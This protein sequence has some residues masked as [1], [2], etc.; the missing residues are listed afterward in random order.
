MANALALI[1]TGIYVLGTGYFLDRLLVNYVILYIISE[2]PTQVYNLTSYL[3]EHVENKIDFFLT[4]TNVK[5]SKRGWRF[6]NWF[7]VLVV[8]GAV[9]WRNILHAMEK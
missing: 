7:L 1:G 8:I 3:S 4:F 5:D 2:I 6:F 9:Q